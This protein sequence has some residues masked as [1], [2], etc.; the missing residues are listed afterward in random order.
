MGD[1]AWIHVTQ[2]SYHWRALC[3]HGNELSGSIK[4]GVFLDHLR[5][6]WVSK[7][8]SVPCSWLV[9]WYRC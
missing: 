9:S 7:K 8:D 5:E 6:Y 4:G 2:Y 1:V 3:E